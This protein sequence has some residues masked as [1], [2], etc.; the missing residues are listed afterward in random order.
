[1]LPIDARTTE[2]RLALTAYVWPDQG[3]RHQRLRGAL[4]LARQVPHEVRRQSAGEL[5][6]SLALRTGATTVLWHSVMWQYVAAEEQQRVRA[7][8]EALGAQATVSAPF[9]HLFHEPVRRAPGSDF[10]FWLVLESWPGGGRR[11]LARVH[12]HGVPDDLG[13]P[14]GPPVRTASDWMTTCR[15]MLR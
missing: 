8:I 10:E 1:M 2:G 9:A 4:A 14:P 15:V 13:A 7:S 6:S 3:H 12:S 5:G 11:F